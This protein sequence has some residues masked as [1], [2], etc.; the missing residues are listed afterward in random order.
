MQEAENFSIV[1]LGKKRVK[2]ILDLAS[3]IAGEKI[4]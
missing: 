2:S 4:T 1:A 3:R